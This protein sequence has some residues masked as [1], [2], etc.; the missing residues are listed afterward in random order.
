[1]LP[2]YFLS[3]TVNFIMGFILV[4]LDKK[5]KNEDEEVKYQFLRDSTF[6]LVLTIFAGLVSVLKMLSPIGERAIPVLGDFIPVIAGFGGFAAFLMRYL[7]AAH[8]F[9]SE[10]SIAVFIENYETVLGLVCLASAVLHL[11]FPNAIFL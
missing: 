6:L 1:M 11:L 5:N 8:N 3:V 4:L 10:N 9:S 2:F 7:K